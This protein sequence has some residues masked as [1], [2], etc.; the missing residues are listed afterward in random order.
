MLSWWANFANN[1]IIKVR[2]HLQQ[3]HF[4]SILQVFCKYCKHCK[5]IAKSLQNHCKI[6]LKCLQNVARKPFWNDFA[7]ILQAFCN[8]FAR[9]LQDFCNVCNTL[10]CCKVLQ[11]ACKSVA[12]PF[13]KHFASVF[14]KKLKKSKFYQKIRFFSKNFEKNWFF[15]EN[16]EKNL[17]NSIF[18]NFLKWNTLQHF[19]MLAKWLCNTF[20]SILQD[21]ATFQSIANIAKVLQNHCKMLAKSFQNGFRATFCKHFKMTLQCLQYLQNTCKMLLLQM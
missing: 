2:L 4:A 12:K 7:S 9:P 17:K 14:L 3:K 6:I 16:F 10:K 5:V 15:S 18:L 1:D 21:P 11:N 8:D 20:T 13:W 19:T